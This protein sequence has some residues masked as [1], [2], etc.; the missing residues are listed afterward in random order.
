MNIDDLFLSDAELS[1]KITIELTD[2]FGTQVT[3]SDLEIQS[4]LANE[5][6]LSAEISDYRIIPNNFN[7][8]YNSIGAHS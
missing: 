7:S 2:Q 4:I 5:V 1:A 6:T 3:I 8:D